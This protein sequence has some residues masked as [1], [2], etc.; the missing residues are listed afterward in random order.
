MLSVFIENKLY[1]FIFWYIYIVCFL[2]Y[3]LN[4]LVLYYYEIKEQGKMQTTG[5]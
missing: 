2:N 4:I 3:L 5:L 1:K